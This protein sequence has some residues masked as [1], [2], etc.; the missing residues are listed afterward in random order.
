MKGA[1]IVK[2]GEVSPFDDTGFLFAWN[3]TA[4]G[5]LKKCPRYF[6]L[7]VLRGLRMKRESVHLLFGGAYAKALET[8]HRLKAEGNDHMQAM[9][10]VTHQAL[11]A[12]W[13]AEEGKPWE[14]DHNLKTRET[15][16]RS[17]VW[18]LEHFIDDATSVLM[19]DG[20]PAVEL[21]CK[22]EIEDGVFLTGHLDRVVEY[23]GDTYIMDQKTTGST[24]SPHYFD[25]WSPSNQMSQ[26]TLMGQLIFDMPV[27]GVIIDAAQIAVGFT[28]FE[29]G[30]AHRTKGQIT[31]FLA[32]TKVW[33]AQARVYHQADHWPMNDTACDKF[34]G[35]AFRRICAK[36][37]EIR[38]TFLKADYEVNFYNPLSEN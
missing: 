6:E 37:P 10:A 14:S 27:K 33:I 3:S 35:C 4:L 20:R 12:T 36:D 25:Q 16:I 18:Y 8:Y 23:S 38:E 34:G 9:C 13:D 19:I 26:Y 21:S 29:R 2:P 32:D 31:E 28:R 1:E 24:L 30:F 5:A 17:I 7:S 22:V 15:L 11:V